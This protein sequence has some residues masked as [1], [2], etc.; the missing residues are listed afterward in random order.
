MPPFMLTIHGCR[1]SVPVSGPQFLR[2]G[3]ATTCFEI[4]TATPGKRLL[5]DAGTGALAIHPTLR[6]G[7]PMEFSILMTHV[8]WDHALALPFFKPLYEPGNSFVFYGREAGGME[9]AEAL[10]RVMRPPWF[11]VNFRSAPAHKSFR[12]VDEDSFWLEE[13]L[14]TPRILHHPDGVIAYRVQN[15]DASLVIATDVEHGQQASDD[16]LLS[17]AGGADVLVYDAQYLPNEYVV[18]KQG[19]GHSTWEA[20]VAVATRAEVGMLVLTSHDPSRDDD[21][22]DRIVEQAR[23]DF[24]NTHAA[25]EGMR[26]EVG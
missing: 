17:L 20:A 23:Q 10:D 9:L 15:A 19:W 6:P 26:I 3:G 22:I 11:P 25:F 16:K 4:E 14:V 18:E 24:E 21:G 5:I 13:F 1:G 12:D 2:H 7:E 8:H